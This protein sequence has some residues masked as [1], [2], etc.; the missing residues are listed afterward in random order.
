VFL[1]ELEEK[2]VGSNLGYRPSSLEEFWL[3][4]IHHLPSGRLLQSFSNS[5]PSIPQVRQSEFTFLFQLPWGRCST[6]WWPRKLCVQ[7]LRKGDKSS[8]RL[9]DKASCRSAFCKLFSMPKDLHWA[10]SSSFYPF[11]SLSSEGYSWFAC[12]MFLLDQ[13]SKGDME[14][15]SSDQLQLLRELSRMSN[16]LSVILHFYL[17]FLD[18][19]IGVEVCIGS[20]VGLHLSLLRDTWERHDLYKH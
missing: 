10:S 20:S 12:S 7:V 14:W 11:D 15:Q 17:W 16:Q 13:S 18:Q 4:P 5:F 2:C 6:F 19:I 9:A 1:V 8:R 3:A